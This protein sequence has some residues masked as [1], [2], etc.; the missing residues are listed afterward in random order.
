MAVGIIERSGE[1]VLPKKAMRTAR[2]E[3]FR[4]N[5]IFSPWKRECNVAAT[6]PKKTQVLAVVMSTKGESPATTGRAERMRKAQG[7]DR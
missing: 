2:V 6:Q 4:V 5:G 1:E 3:V 7:R